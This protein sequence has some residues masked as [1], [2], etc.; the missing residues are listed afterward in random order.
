MRSQNDRN[1]PPQCEVEIDAIPEPH[2]AGID[3]RTVGVERPALRLEYGDE[4]GEPASVT[5]LRESF[6]GAGLLCRVGKIS[7]ALREVFF[8]G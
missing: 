6:R 8:G 4:V 3:E 7:L 5:I 1:H 2:A